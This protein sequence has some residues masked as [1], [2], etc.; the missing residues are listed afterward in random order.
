MREG[1]LKNGILHDVET[2][3]MGFYMRTRASLLLS[4]HL[5]PGDDTH[6]L[7]NSNATATTK[8]EQDTHKEQNSFPDKL[9]GKAHPNKSNFSLRF[10]LC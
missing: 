4:P 7:N 3:R 8:V 6:H 9:M 1:T 10:N 2:S 5:R